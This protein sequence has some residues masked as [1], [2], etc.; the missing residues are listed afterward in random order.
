MCFSFNP[1]SSLLPQSSFLA[2]VEKKKCLRFSKVR[3]AYLKVLLCCSLLHLHLLQEFIL[4]RTAFLGAETMEN[5]GCGQSQWNLL[6]ISVEFTS[7]DLWTVIHLPTPNEYAITLPVITDHMPLL[8]NRVTSS[9]SAADVI[10]KHKRIYV[11][12][13]SQMPGTIQKSLWASGAEKEECQTFHLDHECEPVAGAIVH[14][15]CYCCINGNKQKILYGFHTFSPL[16]MRNS[17]I[18]FDN[19]R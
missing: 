16:S 4:S 8:E 18:Q 1:S 2:P 19:Q 11:D 13:D 14:A 7:S 17:A 6:F 10:H 3:L 15:Q 12:S 5:K 9:S